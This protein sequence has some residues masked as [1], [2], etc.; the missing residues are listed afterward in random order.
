MIQSI[1]F[2]VTVTTVNRI[3]GLE[4]WW[5]NNITHLCYCPGLCRNV[6]PPHHMCIVFLLKQPIANN[7][8][9]NWSIQALQL[10]D[11]TKIQYTCDD[12]GPHSCIN[13]IF[14]YKFCHQEIKI[15][16]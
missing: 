4:T 8:L 12:E 13:F 11:L 3:Y 10:V 9:N 2:Y 16:V 1:I 6:V 14:L 15:Y 5:N 7:H